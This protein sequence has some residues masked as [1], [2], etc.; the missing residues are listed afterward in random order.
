MESP[1][2]CKDATQH[3]IIPTHPLSFPAPFPSPPSGRFKVSLSADWTCGSVADR[4]LT[5]DLFDVPTTAARQYNGT[6]LSSAKGSNRPSQSTIPGTLY[7]C[8]LWT[9]HLTVVS[10]NQADL[11]SPRSRDEGVIT[12]MLQVSF[13]VRRALIS[14][15]TLV[16]QVVSD[17]TP[18]LRLHDVFVDVDVD[19]GHSTVTTPSKAAKSSVRC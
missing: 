2:P 13:C 8:R 5:S 12:V 7:L 9:K 19:V 10:S 16:V 3:H 14:E 6:L 1:K 4:A 11:S 18:V 17:G 15:T